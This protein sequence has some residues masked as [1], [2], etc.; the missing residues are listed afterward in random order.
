MHDDRPPGDD[1][2]DRMNG[3]D[4]GREEGM[5]YEAHE[6]DFTG[7]NDEFLT[8][9]L[10]HIKQE[11]A[12]LDMAISALEEQPHQDRLAIARLKKKKLQLKDKIQLV[13][14]QMTPDIIA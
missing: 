9:R 6:D 10:H 8:I 7:A 13:L 12:D 2:E 11:H 14:D 5:L 1:D 4:H 3:G